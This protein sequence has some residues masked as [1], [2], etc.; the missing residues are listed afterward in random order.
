MRFNH[1]DTEA[2]RRGIEPHMNADKSGWEKCLPLICVHLRSSAVPFISVLCASVSLWFNSSAFA[3][4]AQPRV[5]GYFAEWTDYCADQIP[6]DKLTHINYAFGV[7]KDG[8][9]ALQKREAAEAKLA[10]MRKLKQAHPK[11]QTLISIGGWIDSGPFSDT[12]LTD[13]TRKT[14]AKSCVEFL[15]K[16]DL[17]GVDIDWEFPGGGGYEKE[18]FRKQDTQ[19]FT[20]LLQELR[21]QLDDAGLADHKHYLLTIAAPA[22]GT[23]LKNIELAKVHPLLDFLN[24]MAYDFAG[25][26]SEKTN[27][28]APLFSPPDD[29]AGPSNNGDAAMK[30]YLA[31]GV[32][33]DKIVLGV[34]FYARAWTGVADVNHGLYQPHRKKPAKAIASA[35][36]GR[37]TTSKPTI[38]TK[39]RSDSGATTPRS[40]GSS[41]P[42]PDSWSAT[43]IHNRFASRPNTFATITS[44]AS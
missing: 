22:G 17:D 30:A 12:A 43:T 24:V 38:S 37:S 36:N 39:A 1:R 31:G 27:F 15:R 16:Y 35:R 32:P 14:F 3:A 13:Q 44:A 29:P 5:V 26:W 19:N 9:C 2:Q 42:N 11:L 23:H 25:S 40:P 20:A 41:T 8:Q 4:S 7:I 6:A 34:P 21:R 18:E 10:G 33:P 28:N